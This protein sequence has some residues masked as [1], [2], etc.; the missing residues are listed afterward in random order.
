M[1]LRDPRLEALL[2]A[3]RDDRRPSDALR[4]ALWQRVHRA[5][6]PRLPWVRVAV[7]AAVAVAALVL[8]WVA[9]GELSGRATGLR[10]AASRVE[11][12]FGSATEPTRGTAAKGSQAPAEPVGSVAE[13]S[14]SVAPTTAITPDSR[15]GPAASDPASRPGRRSVAA[16]TADSEPPAKPPIDDLALIEAAEAALRGAEPGRALALLHRHEQQFP[17]A[18]TAEE[19]QALRVLALCA[20]GREVEG[21]GAR[22]AFLR[23]HPRSAYRERIE[24]ACPAP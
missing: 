5:R 18:P 16:A 19:R 22:S 9:I 3:Y 7:A 12:P 1:K 20:A 6:R 8:V 4:E 13:P 21:R 15:P 2:E 11:A 17:S 10:G 23:E 14:P 24:K